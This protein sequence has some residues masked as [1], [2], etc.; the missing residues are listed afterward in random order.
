MRNFFDCR[1]FLLPLVL[2]FCGCNKHS[3]PAASSDKIVMLLDWHPEPEFGGFYSALNFG[4]F[5]SH[6]IDASLQPT[7]EGGSMWQLVVNG[8]AD[9]A[10]TSADQVLI[11]RAQN[12]PVV[13]LFAVYQTCPQGVMVHSRRGFK[14]LE[15]VFTHPGL[16]EADPDATWLKFCQK[17]YGIH[18]LKVIPD[19][20]G[21][22]DFLAKPDDSMQCFITS[23]P[24]LAKAKGGDPQAFLIA[25]S[26]YNPYTTVV[27]TTEDLVKKNPAKVKAV[28]QACREGW[29]SYLKDPAPTNAI[30]ARLNKDMDPATFAAA[31]IA[32]KPLIETAEPGS[33]G[34]MSVERWETLCKQLVDL[35]VIK[36]TVPARI[37]L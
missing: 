5:K 24:I 30:M 6:G 10:T 18:D 25:N 27:I 22:T 8:K 26:G 29:Q 16:L 11:A 2:L 9:F 34:T 33:L 19:S 37:V 1:W 23:E 3:A 7:T 31:A 13:A 15:D 17:K 14:S 35:D 12:A 20:Y 21:V 4:S 28:M 36:K 32:Q